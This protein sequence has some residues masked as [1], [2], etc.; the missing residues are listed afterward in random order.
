MSNWRANSPR[1]TCPSLLV[2]AWRYSFST[3]LTVPRVHPSRVSFAAVCFWPASY[4]SLAAA[5]DEPP[6]EPQF[7][8][9]GPARL[10]CVGGADAKLNGYGRGSVGARLIKSRGRGKN[11]NEGLA[12][13]RGMKVPHESRSYSKRAFVLSSN[14]RDRLRRHLRLARGEQALQAPE[15]QR[16]PR[17][18]R[19]EEE[20]AEHVRK[21]SEHVDAKDG[22]RE[23]Q[24]LLIA[25]DVP[26]EELDDLVG[27]RRYGDAQAHARGPEEVLDH[28]QSEVG[29]DER[30]HRRLV[31]QRGQRVY[32]AARVHRAEERGD[33]E[34]V[35]DEA[36]GE[37]RG[38]A[39]RG[40]G[41]LVD[42]ASLGPPLLESSRPGRR[43]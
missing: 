21:G 22:E 4:L 28:P 12:T 31:H 39:E 34:D 30:V 37:E 43:G 23:S 2:S 19:D 16:H 17:G 26:T 3:A 14:L 8:M 24:R 5:S 1:S 11:G 36:V 10:G 33:V 32:L 9:V 27:E 15:F 20:S 38:A 18:P 35:G 40:D 25:R 6:E 13:L 7:P 42:L 41:A 29:C